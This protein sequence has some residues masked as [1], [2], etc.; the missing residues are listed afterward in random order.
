M[1][2][3]F[4]RDG[5]HIALGL[6][7]LSLVPA[8]AGTVRLFEIGSGA[9]IT[10]DNARFLTDPLPVVLHI[11]ASLTFA[12][13]GAFQFVP[14][15]RR[16]FPAWHRA[17]G[18]IVV[19]A[20]LISALSGLVITLT[21]ALPDSDTLALNI[22]RLIVGVSMITFLML[23][24]TAIAN[25]DFAAHR[26]HMIRAYAL[27]LGAGT[28]V[29]TTLPFVLAFGAPDSLTRTVLMIAGWTI[30]VCLAE[31]VIRREPKRQTFT[32]RVQPA[33]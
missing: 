11:S 17:A 12:L 8:I 14:G 32:A 28:Q 18:R 1:L 16:R 22:V 24:L 3:T 6:V 13:L 23:G 33:N 15:F 9:A 2:T 19:V 21:Y 10:P 31:W 29:L 26:A 7:L 20:G 25:R 30:N 27:G 5:W 4:R